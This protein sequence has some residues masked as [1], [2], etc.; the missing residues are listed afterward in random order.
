MML[1]ADIAARMERNWNPNSAEQLQAFRSMQQESAQYQQHQLNEQRIAHAIHAGVGSGQTP[2]QA[3]RM[4]AFYS[5]MATPGIT[6][7]VAAAAAAAAA[8]SASAVARAAEQPV[9]AMGNHFAT[10]D[11]ALAKT[12]VT[13]VSPTKAAAASR[14]PS[15]LASKAAAAA[16]V[17][18]VTTGGTYH[19]APDELRV[20][21][22]VGMNALHTLASRHTLPPTTIHSPP[23]LKLQE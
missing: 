6:P 14:Q 16:A 10:P 12:A 2:Q 21:V 11:R 8:A 4:A 23:M 3:A 1:Q 19:S 22:G 7:A 15:A 18:A 9:L 13:T 5:A 17:A 20:G